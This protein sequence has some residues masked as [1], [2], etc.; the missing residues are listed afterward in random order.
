MGTEPKLAV[1]GGVKWPSSGDAYPIVYVERNGGVREL[2]LDERKYLE[3][4]F[5]LDDGGRPYVMRK[6]RRPRWWHIPRD[7]G[8]CPRYLISSDV[9]INPVL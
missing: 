2:T 7:H 4:P 9:R 6:Y 8:F 5:A 3:T 1:V